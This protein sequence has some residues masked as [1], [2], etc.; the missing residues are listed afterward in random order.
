MAISNRGFAS[1]SIER[2]REIARL[3]GK[4]VPSESRSFARDPDLAAN[5][6][7]KGGANVPKDKRSFSADNR[8]ATE[9]GRKGGLVASARRQK[10]VSAHPQ[11]PP[12]PAAE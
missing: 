2:R 1:M 7:R 5:A 12:T 10:T 4:A 6:G 8:L 3:G 11:T 9:A